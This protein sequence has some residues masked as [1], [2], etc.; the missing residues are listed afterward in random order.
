MVGKVGVRTAGPSQET[1]ARNTLVGQRGVG[2][3][4]LTV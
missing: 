4:A 1:I 2:R 3:A